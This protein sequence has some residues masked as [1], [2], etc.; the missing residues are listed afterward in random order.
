MSLFGSLVQAVLQGFQGERPEH[1]SLAQAVLNRIQNNEQGGLAGLL[2]QLKSK[3]LGEIVQS[4]VGTGPNRPIT[5]QQIGRGLDPAW[6]G[7]LAASVGLPPE[8][9]S[10]HLAE[11]LP[12]IVDR[13]TPDGR[14]PPANADTDSSIPSLAEIA[15]P[16]GNR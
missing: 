1:A 13:L 16:L 2:E 7:Q 8:T 9:V 4:W 14:L 6:I 15:K 3:G 12:K 11:I 5:P 10:Q